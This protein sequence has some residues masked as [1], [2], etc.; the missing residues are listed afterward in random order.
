MGPPIKSWKVA[1]K[2]WLTSKEGLD[3]RHIYWNLMSA[4]GQILAW[5]WKVQI[6]H[7]LKEGNKCADCLTRLPS[8]IPLGE[9]KPDDPPQELRELLSQEALD[10]FPEKLY[11]VIIFKK[12]WLPKNMYGSD[13]LTSFPWKL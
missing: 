11:N 2:E 4:I 10:G 5:N 3:R 1:T 8:K 12:D 9:Y 7:T 13:T 6:C